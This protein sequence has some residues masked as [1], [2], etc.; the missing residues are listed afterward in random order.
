MLNK[1]IKGRKDVEEEKL[2]GHELGID[3][4]ELYG[5]TKKLGCIFRNFMLRGITYIHGAP[6]LEEV[7]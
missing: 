3:T 4:K 2:M 5:R 6:Q 7:T 1:K